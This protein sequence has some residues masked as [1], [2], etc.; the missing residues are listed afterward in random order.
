MAGQEASDA[1]TTISGDR[2]IRMH[3][4]LIGWKAGSRLRE[5]VSELEAA[6]HDLDL[7]PAVREGFRGAAEA[8]GT[9]V[10]MLDDLRRSGSD[11]PPSQVIDVVP[12][13]EPVSSAQQPSE[14]QP[15][16]WQ[17][18]GRPGWLRTSRAEPG[19]WRRP[20]AT[21]TGGLLGLVMVGAPTA[22]AILARAAADP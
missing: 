1:T 13:G 11:E 7:D 8:A 5:A 9:A 3:T 15:S 16:E 20:L 12:W 18:S 14:W 19:R 22:L 2:W 4:A 17:P 21:A 10:A 6:C